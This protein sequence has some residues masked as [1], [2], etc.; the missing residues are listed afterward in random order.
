MF[1]KSKNPLCTQTCPSIPLFYSFFVKTSVHNKSQKLTKKWTNKIISA[2]EF[3]DEIEIAVT[4]VVNV[5][6]QKRQAISL[7]WHKD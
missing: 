1:I 4:S 2:I 5:K 7:A 6:L 3:D